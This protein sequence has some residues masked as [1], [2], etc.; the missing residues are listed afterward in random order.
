MQHKGRPASKWSEL[1]SCRTGANVHFLL[2]MRST[3]LHAEPFMHKLLHGYSPSNLEA[4]QAVPGLR[5]PSQTAYSSMHCMRNW[6]SFHVY[7][8][9]HHLK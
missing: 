6:P 5:M 1:L 9:L 7:S 8:N 2:A 3:W 4:I